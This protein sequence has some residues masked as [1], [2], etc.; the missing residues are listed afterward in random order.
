MVALAR[1]GQPKVHMNM[2]IL[3]KTIQALV[4]ETIT[5]AETLTIQEIGAIPLT[6]MKDGKIVILITNKEKHTKQIIFTSKTFLK[7]ILRQN[8]QT[9]TWQD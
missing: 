5:T 3:Q 6:Q 7:L 4:W 8:T 1:N 2:V 9:Q